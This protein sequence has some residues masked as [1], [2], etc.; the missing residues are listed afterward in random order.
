[1]CYFR[2]VAVITRNILLASLLNIWCVAAHG[3]SV[4][5]TATSLVVD[6]GTV[7][8]I[9]GPLTVATTPGSSWVNNGEIH[10][11]PE[12]LLNEANGAPL[13]GTGTERITSP[14]TSPLSNEEPGGLRLVVTTV[15][16][17]QNVTLVRGHQPIMEP[18]GA[19]GTARWYQ[20]SSDVNSGLDAQVRFGYDEGQLNGVAE[21]DQ[22]LHVLQS[23]TF[24]LAIPSSVDAGN[25]RVEAIGL[26]S[27]GTLTTFSGALTTGLA[28]GAEQSQAMLFPTVADE[29]V[30]VVLE[31]ARSLSLDL[32]DAQGRTLRS[33]MSLAPTR[34]MRLD[35]S[36]LPAGLYLVRIN[37]GRTL[38][39]TRS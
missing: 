31:T 18:G 17:P 8:R 29:S 36:A 14:Y 22:V 33:Y 5:Q 6:P 1:M 9:E 7:L 32:L 13:S 26:D 15:Q 12:A 4:L 38:R 19:V 27:I 34:T 3:Q 25:D 23:N 20:W 2:C 30:M 39:F 28:D 16:P 21:T 11:G 24:W 35:V 37:G 10:L